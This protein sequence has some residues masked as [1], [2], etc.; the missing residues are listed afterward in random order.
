[1][2]RLII[3]FM[4]ALCCIAG[5]QAKTV[6]VPGDAKTIQAGIDATTSGD[7]VLVDDGI[8]SGAGNRDISFYARRIVLRSVNGPEA[9]VI[10]CEGSDEI[11]HRGFYFFSRED[12][13]CV[14]DGFTIRNGYADFKGGAVLIEDSSPKIKNCIFEKNFGHH[15]GVMYITFDAFPQVINCRFIENRT[16]DVGI[17]HARFG[18]R[19][20]FTDC[21][22]I[23]NT[24]KNGIF[25]CYNA[26]PQVR[27][28]NFTSNK[29]ELT[30]GAVFLQDD[31]SPTF[32]D[33][34]FIGNSS[35]GRGGAIYIEERG[36]WQNYCRPVFNNCVLA[37]NEADTGGAVY[38][39]GQV[40]AAFENCTIF[41][42]RASAGAAV[43]SKE[44]QNTPLDF[45]ACIISANAGSDA[46]VGDGSAFDL[47]CSNLYGNTNG[48]WTPN[49][50]RQKN[51]GDNMSADPGFTNVSAFDFRL[52]KESACNA[53]NSPCGYII[54]IQ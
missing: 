37:G 35:G 17:I 39:S 19:A 50:A 22:F 23:G 36:M 54:G 51:T 3:V 6:N 38:S 1:M 12:T 34:R 4:S 16:G 13:T 40:G 7:T 5:V 53:E 10:D 8:Y 48:D 47:T 15:G 33:C 29:T 44:N 28:C 31:S 42:N 21:E 52:T 18:S 2:Q 43:F 26:S 14:V 30:G 32:S 27:R 24:A 45:V 20:V 9:T 46:L 49:I 11:N 41:G 25:L